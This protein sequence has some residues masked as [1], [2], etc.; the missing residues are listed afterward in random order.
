MSKRTKNYNKA[1]VDNNDS[2]ISINKTNDEA[3]NNINDEIIVDNDELQNLEI[4]NIDEDELNNFKKFDQKAI[5]RD[6]AN[7][8]ITKES[9]QKLASQPCPEAEIETQSI[10]LDNLDKEEDLEPPILKKDSEPKRDIIKEISNP[11][12]D[13]LTKTELIAAATQTAD[14]AL[15]TYRQGWALFNKLITIS[16]EKIDRRIAK[17]KYS[18]S[19]LFAEISKGN[20][21]TMSILDFIH[22]YNEQINEILGVGEEYNAEWEAW[23]AKIKPVLIRVLAKHGWIMT[24]EQILISE[25]GKSVVTKVGASLTLMVTTN[26]ILKQINNNVIEQEAK[27]KR[28]EGEIES[29]KES[30]QKKENNERYKDQELERLRKEIDEAKKSKNTENIQVAQIIPQE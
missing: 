26:S 11:A 25:I 18:S 10:D 17:G 6:Y 21:E 19:I 23:E 27:I 2:V 12:K 7:H 8:T 15:S 22:D 29:L 1:I 5:K 28:Q 20:G 24:D 14:F 4:I 30:L 9:Y 13:D 16:D 3:I